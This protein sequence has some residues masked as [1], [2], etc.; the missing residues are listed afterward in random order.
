M[1][2]ARSLASS[3]NRNDRTMA[4]VNVVS[5]LAQALAKAG[6]TDRCGGSPW[7]LALADIDGA[8]TYTHE[9]RRI[10]RL[11]NRLVHPPLADP[12]DQEKTTAAVNAVLRM[13]LD[14][15][16]WVEYACPCQMRNSRRPHAG[17]CAQCLRPACQSCISTQ[18]KQ[19]RCGRWICEPC[20]RRAG[21][22]LQASD[23]GEDRREAEV[24]ACCSCG[25]LFCSDCVLVFEKSSAPETLAWTRLCQRC[26]Q[27]NPMWG[28]PQLSEAQWKELRRS[29]KAAHDAFFDAIVSDLSFN[30]Q[31]RDGYVP[32]HEF[33]SSEVWFRV[34]GWDEANDCPVGNETPWREAVRALDILLRERR[35]LLER[36]TTSGRGN[37][38]EYP[39]VRIAK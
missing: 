29:K 3:S 27:D 22:L 34:E 23:A 32:L 38:I 21:Q 10:C 14:L 16:K 18:A 26:F 15:E 35:V 28:M 37:E 36:V 13:I 2:D 17:V 33:S 11:R 7:Q 6:Y 5:D 1:E 4:I 12:P 20:R 31:R 24:A 25:E 8:L 19:C 9:A 39:V 30:P